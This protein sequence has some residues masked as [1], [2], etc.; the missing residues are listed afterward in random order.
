[1]FIAFI[2]LEDMLIPFFQ[3]KIFDISVMFVLSKG[4][5]VWCWCK[6]ASLLQQEWADFKK[7]RDPADVPAGPSETHAVVCYHARPT[8]LHQVTTTHEIT[9]VDFSD[10]I[11]WLQ[12]RRDACLTS[13]LS[14]SQTNFCSRLD[15]VLVKQ[16]FE[17]HIKFVWDCLQKQHWN[18]AWCSFADNAF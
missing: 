1:M 9:H 7:S 4:F 11:C 2:S 15:H 12:T 13:S 10:Q 16:N 6:T 3:A 18:I 14:R 5:F 8:R 17:G